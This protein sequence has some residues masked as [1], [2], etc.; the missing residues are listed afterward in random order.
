[1]QTFQIFNSPCINDLNNK[2]TELEK[3]NFLLT[4]ENEKLKNKLVS[5]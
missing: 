2:I 4:I 3:I 1:M 5:S